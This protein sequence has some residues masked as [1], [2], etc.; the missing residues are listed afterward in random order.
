[1]STLHI[2][3]NDLDG[4]GCGVLIK[5][6][7][8]G[9]VHTVYLGYDDIDPFIEQNFHK[10]DNIII[11]DVS[12]SYD[13]VEMLAGE[14]DTV[15]ID[16]HATSEKLKDFPFT[17]HD[18]SVCATLLTYRWLE[19]QGYQVA[20]YE[21]FA[22][23]VDDV[24]MWRLKRDD[25]L[26]MAILFNLMGIDRMEKR[27]LETPYKGFTETEKLFISL[28][29]E[30]KEAYITK[31]MRN[32]TTWKDKRGLT[33]CAVFAESYASELGNAII[34]DATADYVVLIN[35]QSKKVSMRSRK[36]VD[37][38][39]I[40]ENN[41]GGGHKNAAGFSVK[42]ESFDLENILRKAGITD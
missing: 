20:P 36:E 7:L 41:G 27:F 42:G 26:K 40:A 12:P 14:I 33:F 21:E 8:P 31:A 35:A 1:M 5:K 28:E 37:I 11:T 19:K 32:M 3:H 23:C 4:L 22:Q 17:I 10:Y 16:H 9:P 13:S 29:E 30:R 2:S 34:R 39:A 15:I 6:Y 24:D 38:R 18:I 25:S